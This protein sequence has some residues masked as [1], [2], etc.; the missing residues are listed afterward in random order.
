MARTRGGNA[1]STIHKAAAAAAQ[2]G[3]S[4]RLMAIESS[5]IMDS[6]FNDGL[7]MEDLDGL[8]E[9]LQKTGGPLEPPIVY[10]MGDGSYELI[11]GHRRRAAWCNLLGNRSIVCRVRDYEPDIEKRFLFHAEANTKTRAKDAFFWVSEIAQARKILEHKGFSGTYD[12]E[13]EAIYGLLG[14]GAS[15]SQ[16]ARFDG[17]SRLV[18]GLQSL[19]KE[20]VSVSALYMAV[21]LPPEAQEKAAEKAHAVCDSGGTVTME[22]FRKIIGEVGDGKRPQMPAAKKA[23]VP[24]WVSGQAQIGKILEKSFMSAETEEEIREVAAAVADI[25]KILAGIKEK[26]HI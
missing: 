2:A 7:A 6:P 14:Q 12:E 22:V 26:Y 23:A 11:S 5:R 20:N 8:A 25:E 21:R 4:E 10:D 17:F 18:P 16:I 3:P 15:P 24:A 9:S 13:R 19:A 1:F